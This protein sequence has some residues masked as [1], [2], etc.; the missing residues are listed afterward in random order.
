VSS[1]NWP[2]IEEQLD[3][4]TQKVRLCLELN[5]DSISAAVGIYI[6][7]Q[8][9]RLA[10]LKK[11]DD[12]TQDPVQEHLSSNGGNTFLWVALVCQDL[13]KVPRRN[14]LARLSAFPPDL[15]SL[16]QRMM[17]Q[18]HNSDD[19]DLSKQILAI[20]S[21]VYRPITIIELASFCRFLARRQAG[22]IR[23]A[24]SHRQDLGRK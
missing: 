7:D 19:A 24:R 23:V 16:Y 21:M 20:L 2:S 10:R 11:Y 15:D 12:K 3:I 17:D 18:I 8:V 22:R 4:A 14:V 9:D 5:E 1:L 6:R 13:V